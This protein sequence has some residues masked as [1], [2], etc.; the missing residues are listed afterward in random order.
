MQ[1]S[2]GLESNAAVGKPKR[3]GWL[4]RH[5]GI[6][7]FALPAIVLFLTFSVY[8]IIYS[9]IRSFSDWQL[10]GASPFVGLRNYRTVLADPNVGIAFKNALLNFV[11]S[12]PIQVVFG[13]LLAIVL[14]RP[15]RGR[16]FFRALFYIPVLVTW[17]VVI[18][19]YLYMFNKDYG[20]I[21]YLLLKTHLISEGIDWLGSPTR[22]LV[23]V[24]AMGGWKGIGWA[25]LIFL[26]GL[27]SIPTDLYEASGLD[28]AS[29]W[30]QFRYITIPGLRNTTVFVIVLLSIGAFNVFD[31]VFLLFTGAAPSDYDVP[32]SMIYNKAFSELNFGY[33]AALSYI[34]AAVI[35]MISVIQFKVLPK[36]SGTEG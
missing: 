25:M 26:A 2:L 22:T 32:L 15:I 24:F 36:N 1:N 27:Q 30:Q 11:V 3:R 19:I 35:I 20:L 7:L 10:I 6:Y 29:K 16:G 12:I 5:Y 9:F 28:G 4:R 33:S 17:I 18:Q 14:D 21:N 34:M 31:Q 23:S 8:P 13:L